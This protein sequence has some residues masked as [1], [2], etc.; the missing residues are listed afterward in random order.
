MTTGS[1]A[2]YMAESEHEA[3]I[4]NSAAR[5]FESYK[6][7]TQTADIV[8]LFK[9]LAERPSQCE[10]FVAHIWDDP[11]ETGLLLRTL[12]TQYFATEAR[13]DAERDHA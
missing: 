10:K 13:K 3:R 11:I 4:S 1:L 2:Q 7:H 8:E 12:L 5:H 6:H 9:D